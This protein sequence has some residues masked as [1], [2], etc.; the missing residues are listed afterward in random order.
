MVAELHTF[1]SPLIGAFGCR[2]KLI[3][4]YPVAVLKPVCGAAMPGVVG[5]TTLTYQ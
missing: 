4:S 2:E 3:G 1:Y 5:L